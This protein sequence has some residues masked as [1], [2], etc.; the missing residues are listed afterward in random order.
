MIRIKRDKIVSISACKESKSIVFRYKPDRIYLFG[1]IK[2]K[3]GVFYNIIDSRSELPDDCFIKDGIV[4]EKPCVIIR[5]I[6]RR[7]V[8]IPF[9]TI[10][11][12]KAYIK[13]VEACKEDFFDP[14]NF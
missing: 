11:Q 9:D 6:D 4:Y 1:L 8:K 10:E 2:I 13:R 12:C 3:G 14:Y 7:N 5:M